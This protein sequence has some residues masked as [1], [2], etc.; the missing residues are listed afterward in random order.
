MADLTNLVK[1]G[2]GDQAVPENFDPVQ[3][4]LGVQVEMEHTND[5]R[6]AKEITMDHLSE[7]PEYY[8]KLIK[9]WIGR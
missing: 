1:G 3:I 7:N 9:D 8:S 4:S 5:P 6:I 2:K